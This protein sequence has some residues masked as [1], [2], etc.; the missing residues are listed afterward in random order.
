MNKSPLINTYSKVLALIVLMVLSPLKNWGQNNFAQASYQINEQ[1]GLNST[2]SY[3]IMKDSKDNLWICTDMG[4]IR[5]DGFNA[6]SFTTKN[7]LPSNVIFQSYEDPFGR[8]WALSIRKQLYYIQNDSVYPYRY[9]AILDTLIDLDDYL[10]K[11][12]TF[13]KDS[14]LHYSNSFKGAFTIDKKGN[15]KSYPTSETE[16]EINEV[17]ESFMLS[18]WPIHG[19]VN[20]QIN[21]SNNYQPNYIDSLFYHKP[22]DISNL[23]KNTQQGTIEGLI[24]LGGKVIALPSVTELAANVTALEQ[25]PNTNEYWVGKNNRTYRA[26]YQNNKLI[27]IKNSSINHNLYVS[28]IYVDNDG[29]TWF[30]TLEEGVI[31]LPEYKVHHLTDFTGNKIEHE[32]LDFAV[33]NEN[34][35]LSFKNEL[36]DMAQNTSSPSDHSKIIYRNRKLFVTNLNRI[37]DYFNSTSYPQNTEF[38]PFARD[39]YVNDNHLYIASSY[40]GRINTLTGETDTLLYRPD[41]IRYISQVAFSEN[42]LFYTSKNKLFSVFKDSVELLF[43]FGNKEITDLIYFQDRLLISTKNFGIY[44]YSNGVTKPFLNRKNGLNNEKV[45]ILQ[46]SENGRY[47]Y[48]GCFKGLEI[49]DQFTNRCISISK[50]QGLTDLKI[51]KLEEVNGNLYIATEKGFYKISYND[52]RNLSK[53]NISEDI[54]PEV[55][56]LRVDGDNYKNL[57]SLPTDAKVLSISFQI[58]DLKNWF[59][60]KYQYQI[61]G[62]E[63]IN[64]LSPQITLT[65]PQKRLKINL[66]YFM[67][68]N[69]W[70]DSMVL[71]EGSIREPFYT[72]IWFFGVLLF[73]LGFVVFLIL[74]GVNSSKIKKLEKENEMLSY[75]QRMQNARMKPHFI[76]NV[77]NSIY[78]F[79]LFNENKNAANYLLKFSALMRSVLE[80]SSDEKVKISEEIKLLENYLELENLRHDNS[81]KY[82][83]KT[84][85]TDKFLEIPSLMIQP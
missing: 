2:E 67:S 82:D 7:G 20:F 77:L 85:S 74:K 38:L 62:G 15:Y 13:T 4:L 59:N 69:T 3:H 28:S 63:W 12:I 29:N 75:Q 73:F 21:S 23:K 45:N 47:L 36:Y 49:Y 54:R 30:S 42:K 81:F 80:N 6:T 35:L 68:N 70:S 25:I 44:Q 43:D 9:N 56:N 78:S 41:L 40:I 52:I 83:I 72:S 27:E 34:T 11:R 19:K 16:F 61:N 24:L 18:C 50:N 60:K 84:H 26:K 37:D 51:N 39:V 58:K 48:I 1:C 57:I 46:S 14:T 8:V 65:N 32:V 33:I 53:T 10:F 71:I 66:R 79:I 55:T 22:S 5:Y 76:F 31:Y 17:E 64:V